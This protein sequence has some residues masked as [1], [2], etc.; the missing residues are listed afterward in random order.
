[1]SQRPLNPTLDQVRSCV[2]GGVP[3]SGGAEITFLGEGWVCWAFRAG[4][5]VARFPTNILAA[6]AQDWIGDYFFNQEQWSLAEQNYQRVFQSTNW[7]A[8]DLAC[9]AR[10][11]GSGP[12]YDRAAAGRGYRYRA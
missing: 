1:M 7:N 10:S 12:E 8:A 6:R 4:D 11:P 5:Y 2:T 3:E 9:Q